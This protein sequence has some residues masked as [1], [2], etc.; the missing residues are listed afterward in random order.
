MHGPVDQADERISLTIA[1]VQI[2]ALKRAAEILQ[3]LI[4]TQQAYGDARSED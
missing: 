3:Q 2:Y 1:Q 4:K